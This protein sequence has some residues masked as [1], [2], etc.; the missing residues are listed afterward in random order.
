VSDD[1]PLLRYEKHRHRLS[2]RP[3]FSVNKSS[4]ALEGAAEIAHYLGKHRNTISKWIVSGFLPATKTPEGKWF[5][6]TSLIDAWIVAGNTAELAAKAR[7]KAFID[8]ER[9]QE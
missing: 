6:T 5:I 1:I 4:Y 9:E 3:Q 7:A 2:E 8:N